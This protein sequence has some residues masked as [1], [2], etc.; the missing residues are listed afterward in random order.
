[1]QANYRWDVDVGK[2]YWKRSGM[3][4]SGALNVGWGNKGGTSSTPIVVKETVEIENDLAAAAAHATRRLSND[5]R[6]AH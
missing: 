5:P 2:Y 4:A 1:M 3:G 6:R